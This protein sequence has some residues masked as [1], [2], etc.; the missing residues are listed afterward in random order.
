MSQT[1]WVRMATLIF[2]MEKK[3]DSPTLQRQIDRMK[4]VL[5]E[6]DILLLNPQGEAYHDTRTDL[7]ARILPDAKGALCVV[8]VI[9]PVIYG[10]D[11]GQRTLLQ[12]GVVI[13]GS[14]A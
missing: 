11:N 12:R 8:D 2:E 5:E 1:L 4:A 10:R 6:A 3:N 13:V 7:E 14:K 9:K